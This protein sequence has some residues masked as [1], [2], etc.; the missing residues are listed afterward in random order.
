MIMS[1]PS[2]PLVWLLYKSVEIPSKHSKLHD[3]Y[4]INASE[5]LVEAA[6]LLELKRIRTGGFAD[7]R[8]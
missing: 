2:K 5:A 6:E 4:G 3:K 7:N 8:P 1:G